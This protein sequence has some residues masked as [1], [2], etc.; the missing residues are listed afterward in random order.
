MKIENARKERA[1]SIAKRAKKPER[2]KPT[3]PVRKIRLGVNWK[4]L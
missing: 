1:A 4:K 2:I 3:S